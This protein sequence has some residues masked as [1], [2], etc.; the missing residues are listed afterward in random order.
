[1]FQMRAIACDRRRDSWNAFRIALLSA[2][3]I[4][5]LIIAGGALPA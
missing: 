3:A 2:T 1:M 4:A 5:A